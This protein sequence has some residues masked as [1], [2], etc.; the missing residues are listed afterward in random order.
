MVIAKIV[1]GLNHFERVL[2]RNNLIRK[3]FSDMVSAFG[4][5]IPE[6]KSNMK[7]TTLMVPRSHPLPLLLPVSLPLT[8]LHYL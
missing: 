7:I 5:S 8:I 4:L 2:F 1:F 6:E 3:L